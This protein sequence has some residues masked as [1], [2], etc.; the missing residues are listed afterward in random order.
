MTDRGARA[1]AAKPKPGR[2]LTVQGWQNLVLSAMG[3]VVLVGLVAGGL[4][5]H[6]TDQLSRELIDN[7]QPARG[8]AYALQAALRDQETAVRGYVITADEQFLQ[9]YY[10][11]Q[12][13]EREAAQ[14]V[15][16]RV[17]DHAELITDL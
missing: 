1:P 7:V 17:G 14:N 12:D 8:Q 5:M 6:R 16:E 9:P 4:L 2:R 15:R 3:V 13:A 11:G 10:T